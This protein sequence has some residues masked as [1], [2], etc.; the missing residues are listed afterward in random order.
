ML[1]NRLNMRKSFHIWSLRIRTFLVM[2]VFMIYWVNIIAFPHRH[3]ING[4]LIVHS[5]FHKAYHH[6]TTNGNHTSSEINLISHLSQYEADSHTSVSNSP[7]EHLS[8]ELNVLPIY[9]PIIN[10]WRLEFF[11]LR[12]PPCV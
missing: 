4:Q 8:G 3:I 6:S 2:C 9:S 12:G 5:H 1:R 7:T 11:I 10:D